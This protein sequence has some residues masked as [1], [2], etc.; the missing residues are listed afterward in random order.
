LELSFNGRSLEINVFFKTGDEG[1]PIQVDGEAWIQ[2]PGVIRILHKNRVQMLCRNR[3]LEMSLKSW[4]EKQRQHS[5]SIAK[6]QTSVTSEYA[7]ALSESLFTE[8]ETYFLLSFIEVVSTLVKWVK[9]LIISHPSLQK[10]LYQV[11]TKTA[12]SLE[13]I[14]P[15]GRLLEG[16]TLRAKLTDLVNSSK[17]LYE[18]SC[19]LLRERG[20]SLI[21]REDLESKLSA[22]LANME[23]EIRKV[24]LKKDD[25]GVIKAY[26]NCLAP[27]E[28]LETG[29]KKNKP[30]WLRFRGKDQHQAGTSG[31]KNRSSSREAVSNW[32]VNEV[33]TWLEAMQLSEYVDTFVKNDIRGKE[34][35]TLARRDLKDL[36]VTKVGHV[37]RILQAIKDL[38]SN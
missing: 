25:D 38:G 32:G 6:E 34:L 27:H 12:D 21:M 3:N 30:F 1:V 37:K 5:I 4:Q 10:D 8:R 22:A 35:L 17:Q 15:N 14:H 28:E 2:N 20:H 7:T 18:D 11:A 29:R 36:G 16:P 23:M 31:V 9:F 33:T 26:L 19:E 24:Q 13:A